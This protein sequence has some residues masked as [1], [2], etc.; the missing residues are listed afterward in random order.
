MA[1]VALL[2]REVAA[3]DRGDSAAYAADVRRDCV[4]TNILGAVF[5]GREAFEQ[6][7]ARIFSTFFRG[8]RMTQSV[9]S[10]RFLR[11]DVAVAH[12]DVQ[13][14]G[15]ESLPPGAR[16]GPDGVLRTRLEQVLV[17]DGADWAIAAYHNVEV[18]PPP[19][20]GG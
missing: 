15:F 10:L 20:A 16:A 12:L 6:A 4:M 5:T 1:I 2:D 7:H 14:A 19:P 13:V 11:P 3:W 17:K 8:S 18:K 9:R